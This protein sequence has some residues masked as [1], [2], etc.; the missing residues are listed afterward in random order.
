[1]APKCKSSASGHL[2]VPAGSQKVL[3]L[4][5]KMSFL[6]K[7]NNSYAEVAKL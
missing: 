6:D 3:P 4:S 1:M 5:E 7:E 2:D